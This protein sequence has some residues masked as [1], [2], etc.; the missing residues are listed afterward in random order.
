MSTAGLTTGCS[1]AA[2]AGGRKYGRLF[3]FIVAWWSCTAWTTFVASNCQGAANFLLSEIAVFNLPFTTDV[4]DIKFR[5]VQWIVSELFLFLAIGMN[6]LNPKTYS[7]IFKIATGII[8]LDFFLNIIWLPIA[9]SQ[10]Y[11]FQ[12]AEFVFTQTYNETGAPPVWNWMLSFYVTAGIL[13]G[14]EASGH[15]SEE[16][17]NASSTA[18]KGIFTSALASSL[19]GFPIVILF[20]FCTPN[21]DTLY[22]FGAPQPFVNLYAMTLGMGG[23]VFMNIICILGLV[24]VCCPISLPPQCTYKFI[25]YYR[26]RCSQLPSHL[27]S[28]QRRRAALLWLDQPSLWQQRATQRC[29][30]HAHRRRYFTLHDPPFA[31]G[32]HL[33]RISS[34]RP[35]NHRLRIDLFRPYLSHTARLPSRKMVSRPLVPS[36]VVRRHDL[37]PLL[38]R[39]PVLSHR[40]PSHGRYFQLFSR[41]LWSD[42]NLWNLDL[43]VHP[44]G[45]VVARCETR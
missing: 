44:R 4:S 8:M 28:R 21:L 9:V 13:V 26:R 39:N 5:A 11:G 42:H 6:Y 2:E 34:R 33:S 19:L 17:K 43:V 32:L 14:F 10:T 35:Y 18:A 1:W 15:I 30:G 45:E 37:E 7:T 24:F 36:H 16:T 41:Y 27:G 25:E 40:V 22:S 38:G 20:L 23:H 31:C 3:G 29:D 12:S